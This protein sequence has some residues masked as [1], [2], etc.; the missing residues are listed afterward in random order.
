MSRGE[1]YSQR[2]ARNFSLPLPSPAITLW[3]SGAEGLAGCPASRA[4]LRRPSALLSI[5][6]REC[7]FR[8]AAAR[9]RA[10]PLPGAEVDASDG[11]PARD[12]LG[13][14]APSGPGH[15]FA[16]ARPIFPSGAFLLLGDGDG[17]RI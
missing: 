10:L 14:P 7:C 3:V 11:G 9:P 13:R 12:Y 1:D 17:R 15:F 8:L 2:E 5:R 16:R 4:A 6:Q